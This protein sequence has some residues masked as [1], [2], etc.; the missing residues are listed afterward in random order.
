[1]ALVIDTR[2]DAETALLELSGRL[3]I[4]DLPLR[5]QI[6]KLLEQGCRF[7]ILDIKKVDYMDS[8]GLGQLVSLWT[9][10]RT[11][12]GNLVLMRPN[13]R[14]KRLFRVTRLNVVF[15]VFQDEERARTAIRR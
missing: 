11:R 5:D 15:D 8:S 14:I 1:M 3:W 7:F 6:Q 13:E 4:L 12:D 9:S 10:V 2:I